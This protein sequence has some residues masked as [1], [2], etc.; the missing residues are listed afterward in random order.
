MLRKLSIKNFATINEIE[1]FFKSGFLVL[2]GQTGAG[3]SII[4]GALNQFWKRADFSNLMIKQKSY[5]GLN[6]ISSL[7]FT[8]FFKSNNIDYEIV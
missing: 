2:T 6:F 8:N 5:I 3:K 7:D 1:I 4:V